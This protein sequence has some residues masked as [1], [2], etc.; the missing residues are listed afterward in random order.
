MS[1]DPVEDL[2]QVQART[3]SLAD[4]AERFQLLHFLAQLQLTALQR[5][6]QIGL[7][8]GDRRLGGEGGQHRRL[9]V[10]K[11][12]DLDPPHQQDPDEFVVQLHGY[13]EHSP[14][15]GQALQIESGVVRVH[16]HVGDLLCRAV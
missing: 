9:P 2:V 14:Q 1:D 12:V 15:P 16:Q 13:A 10:A 6:H 11:G 3:D 7:T 4:S 8:N 5:A